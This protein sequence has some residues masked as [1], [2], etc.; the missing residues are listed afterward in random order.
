[1]MCINDAVLFLDTLERL[2]FLAELEFLKA[3]IRRRAT[4]SRRWSRRR[5]EISLSEYCLHEIT[6]SSRNVYS[7][8]CEL[9]HHLGRFTC[10]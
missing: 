7:R 1:M 9:R 4:S 6:R 8:V 3:V 2:F 5:R 10:G